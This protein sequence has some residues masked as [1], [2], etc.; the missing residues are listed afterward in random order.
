MSEEEYLGTKLTTLE[1]IVHEIFE[2]EKFI[3]IYGIISLPIQILVLSLLIIK[4]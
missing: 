4:L 2:I 3:L 1:I